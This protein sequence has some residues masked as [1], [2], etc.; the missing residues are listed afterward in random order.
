MYTINEI[1]DRISDTNTYLQ[2]DCQKNIF[3]I[4]YLF[5]ILIMCILRIK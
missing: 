3:L 1:R 2:E 5:K 4:K